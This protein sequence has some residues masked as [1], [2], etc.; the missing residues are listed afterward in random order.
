MINILKQHKKVVI[1]SLLLLCLTIGIS[2]AM[3]ADRTESLTNTFE[4]GEISTVIDEPEPIEPIGSN[5]ISKKPIIRN[6]GDNP[7]LIRVR[8]TMSP[9][10]IVDEYGISCNTDEEDW[11]YNPED[12]FWYYNGIL[13]VN[14]EISIF[15][16]V[17]STKKPLASQ[18]DNENWVIDTGLEG[19]EI[20]VYHE[21]VQTFIV[22]EETG[23]Q[24]TAESGVIKNA[25]GSLTNAGK[26]WDYFDS[27]E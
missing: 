25:D 20:A 22:D 1:V 14:Q 6:T 11:Y 23:Q 3:F 24:I 21:S 5:E 7:A 9:Q 27:N 4:L 16:K 19:L 26:I 12:E 2:L 18:D 17:T 15:D 8:V 13:G 10:D